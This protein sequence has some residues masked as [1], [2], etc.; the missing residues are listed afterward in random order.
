MSRKIHT[1][2]KIL[3]Q[4][5]EIDSAIAADCG[6]LSTND[7]SDRAHLAWW[8]F[9]TFCQGDYRIYLRNKSIESAKREII[10]SRD[11]VG[12]NDYTDAP[13]PGTE[14]IKNKNSRRH[15]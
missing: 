10:D 14:I 13:F 2:N 3:E 12:D 15:G 6:D 9:R 5:A 4:V 7:D 11:V 1:K 8:I